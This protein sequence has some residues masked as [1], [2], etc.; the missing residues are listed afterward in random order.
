MPWAG[1]AL[2]SVK[3]DHAGDRAAGGGGVDELEDEA[4]DPFDPGRE[5]RPGDT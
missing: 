3:V 2:G 5:E 4:C 1:Q